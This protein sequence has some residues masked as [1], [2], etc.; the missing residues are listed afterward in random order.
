M[1]LIKTIRDGKMI[2]EVWEENNPTANYVKQGEYE[3][4]EVTNNG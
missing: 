2:F 4:K 1:E 3:V